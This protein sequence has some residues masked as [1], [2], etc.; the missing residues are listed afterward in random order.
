MSVR[1]GTE[2]KA[3]VACAR[4][5]RRSW[6]LAELSAVLDRNCRADGRLSELL[7]LEDS[8][9]IGALGGRRRAELK[10][11]H[12]GFRAQELA[13]ADGIAAICHHDH[14]Y[15]RALR[16]RGSP[17]LLHVQGGLGRL[18]ILASEPLVAILG[19][20]RPTD[21]G[22]R[23]AHSL[24]RELSAS[25]VTLVTE[26]TAGIAFA[27]QQGSLAVEGAT[28]T[29]SGDGLG[30]PASKERRD[31]Y[32][33]LAARGCAVSELPANA[34]GRAWGVAAGVRIAAA[35]G[36]V[37]VIVGAEDSP[38]ELRGAS[39]ARELGRPVMALPGPVDSRASTGCH[40]LLRD[41][42]RLVRDATDVLDLLYGVDHLPAGTRPPSGALPSLA[43]ELREILAQVSAGLDTP[44]KLMAA[45]GGD[46]AGS[47]FHA[48]SEL[49]LLGLLGRSDGGRYV[50]GET[51][52]RRVAALGL[53][54]QMES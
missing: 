36:G 22:R 15:P 14:S 40:V 48:L 28:I 45:V 44:G 29:I 49:E 17:C 7:A 2:L 52:R 54:G 31:T 4:C 8:E 21:Y 38:R 53:G 13:S 47:L 51:G 42:A 16:Q 25:G 3:G 9:L 24:A 23:I 35:L 33:R 19:T 12:R 43:P 30:V 37:T 39:I 18:R 27:A 34:R 5:V 41:G 26:R 6:L 46:E 10:R 1:A 50:A 20:S 32:A 11:R